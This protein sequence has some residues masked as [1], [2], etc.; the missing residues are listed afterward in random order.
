ML[1]NS[2]GG[3]V[4]DQTEPKAKPRE[5]GDRRRTRLAEAWLHREGHWTMKR[6]FETARNGY[7]ECNLKEVT[8]WSN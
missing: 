1:K 3:V 4:F 8:G 7:N 5:A 2:A 6:L